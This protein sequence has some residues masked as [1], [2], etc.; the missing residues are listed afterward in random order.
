M[1]GREFR[2][3]TVS[4]YMAAILDNIAFQNKQKTILVHGNKYDL[5]ER[6]FRNKINHLARF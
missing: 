4:M 1:A 6:R 3:G 2:S 5:T